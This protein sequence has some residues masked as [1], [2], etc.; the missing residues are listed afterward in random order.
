MSHDSVTTVDVEKFQGGQGLMTR[1]GGIGVLATLAAVVG[2]F[3][4]P[5]AGALSYV[6][7]FAYWGGISITSVILLMILHTFRAKWPTVL[8][9]GLESMALTAP[10]FIALFIPLAVKL[11]D[12]FTW[13]NPEEHFKGHALHLVHFKHGYLNPTF[14][15]ARG[16]LYLVAASLVGQLLVRWSTKQDATGDEMLTVRQRMLGTG[17]LPFM[18]L[19]LTFAG[20]DWLM[21]LDPVWFS[22]IF[23]VYYFAG[24]VWCVWALLILISVHAKGKNL[25]GQ[26]VTPE[27]LHNLGKFLF[28]FTAFW[29]YIAV[30]QLLLIWI[31]GLPEETPFYIIRMG[32]QSEGLGW[33]LVGLILLF[34][35][36]FIPFFALLSR[37]RKRDPRR[38]RFWAIWALALHFVDIYWL[39]YPNLDAR[40]PVFHWT[41]PAAFLGIGGLAVAFAV[42]RIRG[43]YMVPIKDPYLSTSLRYRQP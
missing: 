2:M 21:S 12:A 9:R 39:V 3:V 17:G 27:H 10:L 24:S 40:G 28:A 33:G 19:V 22:T 31:A 43:N 5:R 4:D 23:G 36:F 8:R 25:F 11:G 26:Y 37:A 13:V 15:F 30:S 18:A 32:F 1:A 34:F 6:I 20:V 7:A 42:W 29:G 14:F 41:L 38:I 16:I 35:H